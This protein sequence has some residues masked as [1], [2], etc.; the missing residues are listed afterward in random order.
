MY[1]I[2]DTWRR[3]KGSGSKRNIHNGLIPAMLA[4][5]GQVLDNGGRQD[6][7]QLV[8]LTYRADQPSIIA[9]LYSSTFVRA[10]KYFLCRK[11]LYCLVHEI[12]P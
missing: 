1:R 5:H 9:W 10:C 6:P 11:V 8:S 12:P 7:Q 3:L 4:V 2:S